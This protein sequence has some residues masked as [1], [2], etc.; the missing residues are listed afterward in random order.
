MGTQLG[1]IQFRGKLGQTVGAK[2][3]SWQRANTIRARVAPSNPKTYKQALQRMK[4]AAATKL[5]GALDPVI[6]RSWQSVG[7]GKAS[8]DHF[9]K[10]LTSKTFEQNPN[11]DLPYIP[12]GF[13][14]ALPAVCPVA[15]GTLVINPLYSNNVYYGTLGTEAIIP[16][17]EHDFSMRTLG[18]WF[19]HVG[20]QEGDQITIIAVFDTYEDATSYDFVIESKYVSF[21]DPKDIDGDF[22]FNIGSIYIGSAGA[23]MITDRDDKSPV[24]AACII[25]RERGS[26]PGLRT[27]AN[28]AC[29]VDFIRDWMSDTAKATA[30]ATY[31]EQAGVNDWPVEQNLAQVAITVLPS[32][33][34]GSVTGAGN[35]NL[36]DSAQL[37]ATA[38][39]NYHF[40]GWKENGQIISTSPNL[41]L[42]VRAPRNLDAQFAANE[43]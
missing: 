21:T 13:T 4:M 41:I 39:E 43:P 24:A 29:S 36:G 17:F 37:S 42:T 10:L 22:Q 23:G 15:S 34:A 5:A 8:R 14:S 20:F 32:N 31:M 40:V 33:A 7:Y 26:V 16:L 2:K 38:A 12:K 18:E 19:E 3:T 28:M 1:V 9:V 11:Y 6:S 25:S 27:A 35:Y 30:A